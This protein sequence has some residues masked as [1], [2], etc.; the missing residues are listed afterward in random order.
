MSYLPSNT[1]TVKAHTN[2]AISMWWEPRKGMYKVRE[3]WLRESGKRSRQNVI[4]DMKPEGGI[5][6]N[7]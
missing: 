3:I 6:D 5:G 4:I 1:N 2:T 7:K